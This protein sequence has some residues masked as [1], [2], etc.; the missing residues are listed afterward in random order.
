[1]I[2]YYLKKNN[3]SNDKNVQNNLVIQELSDIHHI[4]HNIN[5]PTFTGEMIVFPIDRYDKNKI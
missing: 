4:I 2:I 1:M 5:Q 3:Q